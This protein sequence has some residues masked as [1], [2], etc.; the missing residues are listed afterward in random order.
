VAQDEKKHVN[1]EAKKADQAK[2]SRLSSALKSNLLRRKGIN[3]DQKMK[4]KNA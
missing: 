1:A 4:S 3:P 2:K